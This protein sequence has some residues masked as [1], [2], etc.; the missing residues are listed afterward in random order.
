MEM[1][2]PVG[3]RNLYETGPRGTVLCVA[4]SRDALLAQVGAALATGN[5]VRIGAG[6]GTIE[7]L[8][9]ALADQV[10]DAVPGDDEAFDAILFDGEAGALRALNLALAE[11]AGPILPVLVAARSGAYPLDMLVRERS[12][13]TNTAAACGNAN[14]MASD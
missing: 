6:S 5:R 1:P 13:S 14:L 11:R 9:A 4:R 7:G 8:P 3:E 12:V 2:G 10:L